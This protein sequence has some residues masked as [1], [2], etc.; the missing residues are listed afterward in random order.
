MGVRG[1]GWSCFAGTDGAVV[2][3]RHG[4]T[5]QAALLPAQGGP[6]AWEG[7]GLLK[8]GGLGSHA[9][10]SDRHVGFCTCVRLLLAFSAG[11][12]PKFWCRCVVFCQ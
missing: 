11:L 2:G 6:G 7:T 10:L 9:C 3:G 5:D 12:I 8:A 4:P 1:R